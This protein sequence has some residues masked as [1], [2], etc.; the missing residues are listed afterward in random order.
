MPT[1]EVQI[2]VRVTGPSG[3]AWRPARARPQPGDSFEIVEVS[4]AP[5]ETAQFGRGDRVTCRPYDLTDHD[6]VRVAHERAQEK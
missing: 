1:D 6:V 2:Y 4:L 3:E 5:G